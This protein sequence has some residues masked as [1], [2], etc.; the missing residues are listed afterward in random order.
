MTSNQDLQPLTEAEETERTR[1]MGAAARG[2]L[3]PFT[4]ARVVELN[5]RRQAAA[6]EAAEEDRKSV[7]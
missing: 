2:Q 4:F 5:M 1:L 6:G 7:V 3:N